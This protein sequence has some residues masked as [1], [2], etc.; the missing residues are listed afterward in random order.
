LVNRFMPLARSLAM[1]Y[2]RRSE[3]LDDL[4]QV[5]SLGLIK[6]IDGYDPGRGRSTTPAIVPASCAVNGD[7]VWNVRLPRGLQELTMSAD[8]AITADRG[9]PSRVL[10]DRRAVE[11]STEDVPRRKARTRR[12]C[13]SIAP[14]SRRRPSRPWRRSAAPS[15]YERVERT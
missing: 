7:H 9:W 3:S 8:E 11:I 10:P 6:A 14:P 5:A 1:R 2:R 15:G 13:R 12:R 4:I